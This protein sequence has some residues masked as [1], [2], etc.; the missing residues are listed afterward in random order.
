MESVSLQVDDNGDRAE[1]NSGETKQTLRP[2]ALKKLLIS[3]YQHLRQ[4]PASG[5]HGQRRQR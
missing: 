4:R 5:K 2:C 3:L 1:G